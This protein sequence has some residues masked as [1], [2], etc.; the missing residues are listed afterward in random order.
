MTRE[1]IIMELKRRGY[2]AEAKDI[3]KNGVL[4]KGITVL[5]SNNIAPIFY[6]ETIIKNAENN[7]KSLEIVVSEI[8]DAIEECKVFK[9]DTNKLMDRN[10]ILDN[11][12]IGLQKAG[13]ENFDDIEKKLYEGVKGIEKYLYIR[14]KEV[15]GENY[16][17]K[18]SKSILNRAGILSTEAWEY[19]LNNTKAETVLESLNKVMCEMTVTEYFEEM[20]TELPLFIISNKLRIKGASAILNK[21]MLAQFGEKYHTDKIVVFPSSI[22]EMLLTPYVEGMDINICSDMAREIN[23]TEVDLTEQLVDKAFIITLE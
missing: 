10:F 22:H 2:E 21:G 4:L 12:Y 17:I 18:V 11:I 16:S 15:N 1:M 3:I 14:G 13:N 20:D 23:S 6:T 19:A 9:F 7:G 5:T 8:I